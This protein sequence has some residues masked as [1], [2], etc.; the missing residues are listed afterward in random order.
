[1]TNI[2]I[3][4][5]EQSDEEE[6]FKFELENRAFFESKFL[7][8]HSSYYSFDNFKTIIKQLIEEQGKDLVY[9]Y[10]IKTEDGEIVGRVNLVSITRGNFNKA[11]LGYRIAERH[12]GKGYTTNAVR[13]VLDEAANTHKL[14]RIEAGTSPDNI[15]SQIVLI[16]N[17]FQFTGRYNQY[18][19]QN[20]KWID[21]INF[22]KILN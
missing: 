5:L 16:K 4:L 3:K 21:G 14:H 10:L 2:G 8:R 12:Q 18:I 15:G 13:L 1:M 17:G 19:Y 22:E 6:L 20:G 11:E 9:M 7:L